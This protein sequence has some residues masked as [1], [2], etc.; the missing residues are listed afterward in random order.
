MKAVVVLVTMVASSMVNQGNINDV[1]MNKS[2]SAQHRNSDSNGEMMCRDMRTT[3]STNDQS[4]II[5]FSNG[6][7][8]LYPSRL[9]QQEVGLRGHSS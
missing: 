3:S 1:H 5:C 9:Q 7:E 8:L 2:A 4:A 6:L